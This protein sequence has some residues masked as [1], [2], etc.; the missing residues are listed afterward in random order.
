[1]TET[2]KRRDRGPPDNDSDAKSTLLAF[3]NYV[4]EAMAAKTQGFDDRRGRRVCRTI[5]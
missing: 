1:M 2:Q 4:H 3:L 5:G